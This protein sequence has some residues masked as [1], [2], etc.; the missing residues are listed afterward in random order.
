MNLRG[1]LSRAPVEAVVVVEM[2][3]RAV[4]G[5]RRLVVDLRPALVER[6]TSLLVVTESPWRRGRVSGSG[7][8]DLCDLGTGVLPAT[9]RENLWRLARRRSAVSHDVLAAAQTWGTDVVSSVVDGAR[10]VRSLLDGLTER[11]LD[12]CDAGEVAALQMCV[13][14]GYWH[15][16]LT[17]PALAAGRLRPWVVY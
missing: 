2:D 3:A 12:L 5:T 17:T 16:R 4:R 14:A 10:T 11:L 8:P 7:L 13:E 1:L 15:T 6:R 9:C